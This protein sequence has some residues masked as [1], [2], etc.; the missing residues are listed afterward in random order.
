V[1]LVVFLA[2]RDCAVSHH[3]CSAC[4]GRFAPVFVGLGE[5]W[6]ADASA[7]PTADVIAAT[8]DEISATE[9]FTVPTSIFDEVAGVCTRL[10]IV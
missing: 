1:P 2:S 10:G 4:A 3:H 8:L 5:G 7:H 9:P 6:L